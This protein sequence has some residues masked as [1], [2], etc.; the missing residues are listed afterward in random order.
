M[1]IVNMR[2]KMITDHDG[3]SFN[4]SRRVGPVVGK[5]IVV[6]KEKISFIRDFCFRNTGNR[7]VVIKTVVLP[8]FSFC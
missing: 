8:G 1:N 6:A 4:R 3:C 5:K 2:F 7:Y